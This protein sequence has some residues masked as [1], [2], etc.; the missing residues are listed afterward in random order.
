ML[1]RDNKI[2]SVRMVYTVPEIAAMLKISRGE[3]Y[4]LVHSDQFKIVRIGKSIRVAKESF[5]KWL[6]EN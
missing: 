2:K 5:E 6:R 3:A 4:R 1:E